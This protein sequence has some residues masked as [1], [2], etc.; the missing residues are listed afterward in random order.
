MGAWKQ[1]D[2]PNSEHMLLMRIFEAITKLH[3]KNHIEGIL[4]P[5][6]EFQSKV[7]RFVSFKQNVFQNWCNKALNGTCKPKLDF[8]EA[9]A[10][11]VSNR[12]CFSSLFYFCKAIFVHHLS[13]FRIPLLAG[14]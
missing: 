5:W 7:P 13:H 8:D 2:D 3:G 1:T 4:K 11:R 9:D 6:N 10:R 12:K 14:I